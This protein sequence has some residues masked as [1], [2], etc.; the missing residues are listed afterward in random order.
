[1]AREISKGFSDMHL[2]MSFSSILELAQ[3]MDVAGRKHGIT[4]EILKSP[5]VYMLVCPQNETL[6][7]GARI[8]GTYSQ[9]DGAFHIRRCDTV[10]SCDPKNVSSAAAVEL[11]NPRYAAMRV[12]EIVEV[13]TYKML[14]MGYFEVYSLVQSL[15]EA[16]AGEAKENAANTTKAGDQGVS[17]RACLRHFEAEFRGL[18][19]RAVTRT[20][21]REFFFMHP[22][23]SSYLRNIMELKVY[24][25]PT[26]FLVVG[27]LYDPNDEP[28]VQSLLLTE[29]SKAASIRSFLSYHPSDFYIVDLDIEVIDVFKTA[30]VEFFVKTRSVCAYLEESNEDDPLSFQYFRDCNYGEKA[31]LDLEPRYY[32]RRHCPVKLFNLNN[33]PVADPDYITDSLLALAFFDCLSALIWLVSDDL[34]GRISI[35]REAMESRLPESITDMLEELGHQRPSRDI[36][37]EMEQPRR[38]TVP[39]GL[40]VE[41]PSRDLQVPSACVCPCG[42]FQEY[43]VPCVHA[44]RKMQALGID[45]YLYVSTV[46]SRDNITRL[47]PIVPVVNVRAGFRSVPGRRLRKAER[48][49]SENSSDQLIEI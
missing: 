41:A 17:F 33:M 21:D 22:E 14:K 9:Q 7:C 1:M 39:G 27:F 16:C 15:G 47:C 38:Q 4:E 25:R 26:G 35:A 49:S 6:R 20:G 46:Y 8:V 11:A 34:R 36:D 37:F 45:P 31:Y 29:A 30:K 40:V 2:G 12:G 19:P 28:V 13:F 5:Y 18:N 44:V 23:Y 43:L 10:H 48:S 3:T 32:L 24:E 42:K